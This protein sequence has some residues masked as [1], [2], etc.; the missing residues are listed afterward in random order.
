MLKSG[1][2]YRM[3][4]VSVIEIGPDGIDHHWDYWKSLAAASVLGGAG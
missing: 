2:D 4:Y 1:N 3:D